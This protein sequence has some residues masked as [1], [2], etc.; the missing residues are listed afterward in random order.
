MLKNKILSSKFDLINRYCLITGAA[1]LLGEEHAQALLEINANIILTDINIK[2]LNLLKKKLIKQYPSSV[3]EVFKMDVSNEKSIKKTVV[4]LQKKKVN[5]YCLINNAAIDAKIRRNQKMSNSPLFEKT[6]IKDW[7]KHISV[8]LTGAMLCAKNFGKMI[9]ANKTGG[10]IINVASDLS[11]IA[12]NHKIYKKGV[13][14]PVMYSVIKHGIIGLTKYLSTY[15]NNKKLRCNA[16]SPG[17]IKN[18]QTQNFMNKLKLQIPLNRLAV[19][20]DY[21]GAIQFLCSDASNYMT[22]QN[23]IVDGGR[24]VW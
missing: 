3:I 12:P 16:I 17:P 21:R 14:K 4:N 2:K 24:S 9:V 22:G 20:S 13:F 18:N 10:V 19:K 8:G 11:V 15:W 1:G 5:L 6:T 23:L 7:D